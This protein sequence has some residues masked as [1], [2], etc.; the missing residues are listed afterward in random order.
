V[1]DAAAEGEGNVVGH[2]AGSIRVRAPRVP[3]WG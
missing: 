3:D 2:G 1:V